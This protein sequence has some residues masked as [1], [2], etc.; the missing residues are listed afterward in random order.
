MWGTTYYGKYADSY[1]ERGLTPS[2][3]EK[4]KG[5]R[6]QRASRCHRQRWLSRLIE[7]R[8]AHISRAPLGYPEV[9]LSCKANARAYDTKSWHGPH[10]SHPHARRLHL[11]ACKIS[12]LPL[13]QPNL[14]TCHLKTK[15]DLGVLQQAEPTKTLKKYAMQY[16]IDVVQST[17]WKH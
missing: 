4:A 10:Y 5:G 14:V 13:S 3:Y 17:S 12:L 1:A 6:A 2:R 8:S 7:S 15:R 9:F 11:S 16:L